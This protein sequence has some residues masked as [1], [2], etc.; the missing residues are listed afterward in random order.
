MKFASYILLIGLFAGDLWAHA[1]ETTIITGGVGIV[2][3][4]A[5]GSP[6]AYAEAKVF[7]PGD[8]RPFQEGLTDRNG[9]FLFMPAT[10]GTWRLE[11]DDGMGHVIEQRVSAHDQSSSMRATPPRLTRTWAL[12]TGIGLIWGLFGTWGWWRARKR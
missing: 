1:I 11:I 3:R 4:Y 7:A 10:S 2:A 6:A 8:D 9:I 5:D 12:V